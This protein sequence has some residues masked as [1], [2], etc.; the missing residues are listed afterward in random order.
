MQ[1]AGCILQK[2]GFK[3]IIFGQARSGTTTLLEIMKLHPEVKAIAE[4]FN[5]TRG[6]WGKQYLV[7]NQDSSQIAVAL[8]VL[9]NEVN[10]FKHLVEQAS[11]EGNCKIINSTN[12]VISIHRKNHLQAVLSN[13]ICE[14]TKHWRTDKQLVLNHKFK[15]ID[16]EHFQNALSWQ[17]T[18][19]T[20]YYEILM[21][22]R[23][24]AL[25]YED[26]YSAEL[27]PQT[28]LAE[29]QKIFTFIGL[30]RVADGSIIN[31]I[32]NLLDPKNSKL[33]SQES[34]RLIPNIDEIESLGSPENGYLFTEI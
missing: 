33:N 1:I 31:K 24:Q 16:L 21:Q 8:R 34:Y 14:Q 6:S 15:A 30:N 27:T 12:C 2:M 11:F 20:P 29:V 13:F 5:K 3:F 25:L 9:D 18:K 26:F 4:P 17:K 22:R 19:F 10:G 7:D 28:K 23:H 32:L